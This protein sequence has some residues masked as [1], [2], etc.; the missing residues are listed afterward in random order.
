MKLNPCQLLRWRGFFLCDSLFTYD[1]ISYGSI[2][3][4][5]NFNMNDNKIQSYLSPGINKKAFEGIVKIIQGF[6]R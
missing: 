6:F 4:G 3:A 5:T 2:A 1:F